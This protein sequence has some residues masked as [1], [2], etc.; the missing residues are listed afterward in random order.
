LANLLGHRVPL[1]SQRG[2]HVTIADPGTAPRNMLMVLDKKI[3]ITPMETGV[4]IAGTV[5]LAGLDALPNYARAEIFL[6]IG[7]AIMPGLRTEKHSE[8]MGHRPC[9]PDS[10]PVIGRA[11]NL[12]NA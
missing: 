10:L 4:R 3:A 8:W 5:E 1:E 6:G 2:Y 11:P 12:A 7:K 9:L